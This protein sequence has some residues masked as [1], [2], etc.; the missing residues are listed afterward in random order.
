[1]PA[2]YVNLTIK[3]ALGS[4][5]D[6][7]MK[8]WSSTGDLTGILQA[9][10]YV[11]DGD[12]ASLGAKADA[13]AN[14]D[15]GTF[16]LIALT[17]RIVAKLTALA[18]QLPAAL[19]GTGGLKVEVQNAGASARSASAPVALATEEFEFVAASTT[20][21]LG[22]TGAVG[23][24][25]TGIL[26]IP[27]T[28]SPGAVTVKDGT[29]GT[30]RTVFTGGAGSVPSLIPFFIPFGHGAKSLAA[31]GWIVTTGANVAVYAFGDFT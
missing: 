5:N 31:G 2:G 7:T 12:L 18:A 1:M 23:D 15:T 22:A 21:S 20:A 4:G 19:G 25:L 29:A 16:S 27:G 28:T 3:D 24:I 30:T 26:V 10:G 6:R 8:V 13:A 11:D 17:K 14:A 9:A